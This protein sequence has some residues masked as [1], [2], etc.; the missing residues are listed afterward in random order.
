MFPRISVAVLA[1]SALAWGQNPVPPDP[2]A[3][4]SQNGNGNNSNSNSNSNSSGMRPSQNPNAARMRADLTGEPGR[5]SGGSAEPISGRVILSDGGEIGAGVT[6][7]RVCGLAIAGEAHTDSRGRFT[8]PRMTAAAFKAD[9][10]RANDS[11]AWGCELR[12]SLSGYQNGVLPLGSSRTVDNSNA[13]IVLRRASSP[14]S[15]TVSA[16]TL[17]A[18]KEAHRA[19]DKG[20]EAVHKKELERAQKEFASA[21]KSFPRYAAAWLEL[22]KVFELRDRRSQAREAYASA[23]AA[24]G[25]YLFPYERLY[26]LDVKESKWKDAADTSSKVLR[27]NPYE[28]PE[29]FYF[30]AVSNLALNRLDAAE[31][32]ARETTRLEGAQAE[33]RGNYVLAAILWRK[34]DLA[35]AEER[36]QT[37]LAGSPNLPEHISGE[38]MLAD[39]EAQRARR[40][41]REE[42]GR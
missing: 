19:Y 5:R 4:G 30:N 38:K 41:A 14:L 12:A 8:I 33:P 2:N 31:H 16:T 7:Q 40:Q 6:V 3:N 34:G 13:V 42:A 27:L 39:I 20:M 23:I 21:V 1:L 11:A 28:F 18:P 25:Q 10:A 22:G 37:F 17:L 36:M 15:L 24:D 32:S 26:L 35:G 9:S 29:A